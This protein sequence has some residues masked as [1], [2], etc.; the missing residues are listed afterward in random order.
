MI[1]P[2]VYMK[3][4]FPIILKHYVSLVTNNIWDR[5]ESG[6]GVINCKLHIKNLLNNALKHTNTLLINT[7]TEH[8]QYGNDSHDAK[9][10]NCTIKHW[11]RGFYSTDYYAHLGQI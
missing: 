5:I 2:L 7:L 1:I 3:N 11:L 10:L 8:F 9:R 4:I 6:Q